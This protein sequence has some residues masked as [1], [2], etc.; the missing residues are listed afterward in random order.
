MTV[1]DA[2]PTA[3]SQPDDYPVVYRVV[4]GVRILTITAA[5]VFGAGWS[6]LMLHPS[7]AHGALVFNPVLIGFG[8]V[9]DAL[10]IYGIAWALTAQ[11]T[12][13]A[14]SFE[15]RK[16][17]I[18]R[19]LRISDIAGRR[20][21]TGSGAGYPLIVPKSGMPFSI[22]TTSYGLD[23]RFNRWFLRLA[24]LQ[25]IAAEEN[26]ERIRNDASLGATPSERI[27]ADGARKQKFALIGGCLAVAALVLF[28][29]SMQIH[30]YLG[31]LVV[32]SAFLPLAGLLLA[33]AYK[34]QIGGPDGGKAGFLILPVYAPVGSLGF[35][36]AQNAALIHSN[37]VI[38]C[39]FVIGSIL[40]FVLFRFFPKS[41]SSM[42]KKIVLA[43]VFLPFSW[44]YSGS[45]LALGNRMLDSRPYQIVPTTVVGKHIQ[46]GKS[47]RNY[48]LEVAGWDGMPNGTSIRVEGDQYIEAKEGDAICMALYPGR[49]G[50]P[51]MKGINC[52][53][54]DGPL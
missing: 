19:V 51:W 15:Q 5:L 50:F 40:L 41:E 22:D 37:G 29:T 2:R 6:Y 48:Y 21:T 8:A 3:E 43:L 4:N 38:A 34:D 36:A 47:G 24:D 16:P 54:L 31:V 9:F 45:L 49:F 17:F 26:L 14:D 1:S 7:Y 30:D 46:R 11:I 25:K 10:M 20:Y 32:L 53:G 13:N 42:R 39:G 44:V 23:Y 28:Y 35:L 52:S 33:R 12:L 27:A 18:H